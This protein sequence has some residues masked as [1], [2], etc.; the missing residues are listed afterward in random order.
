MTQLE[1]ALI[2]AL[3]VACRVNSITGIAPA[4]IAEIER[5]IEEI[6]MSKNP[7]IS[8]LM[9]TLKGGAK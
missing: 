3:T 7:A 1:R 8:V 6:G 2:H 5:Q 9:A 4:A